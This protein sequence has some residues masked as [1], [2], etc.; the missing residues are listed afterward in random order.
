M[1]WFRDIFKKYPKA[2]IVSS[3]ANVGYVIVKLK[4]FC[5]FCKTYIQFS[6]KNICKFCRKNFCDQHYN[7]VAHNCR[8]RTAGFV[9]PIPTKESLKYSK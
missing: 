5:E 1:G 6:S 2:K 3:E 7:A 4:D 8:N 9:Q